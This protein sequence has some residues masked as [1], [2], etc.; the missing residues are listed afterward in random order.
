MYV[1]FMNAASNTY[2][3]ASQWTALD[4]TALFAQEQQQL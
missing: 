3:F 4:M 1:S 2:A